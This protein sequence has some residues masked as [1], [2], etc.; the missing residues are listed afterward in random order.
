M[1]VK[2]SRFDSARLTE[3]RSKFDEAIR[4]GDSFQDVKKIYLRIKDL[5]RY[6]NSVNV[7]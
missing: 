5:K 4:K 1:K 3:L 2:A 7:E 6:L